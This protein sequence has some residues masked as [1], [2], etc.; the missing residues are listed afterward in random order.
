MEQYATYLESEGNDYAGWL[1]RLLVQLIFRIAAQAK[2]N[3]TEKFLLL[4]LQLVKENQGNP[5]QIYPIWAEQQERLNQ[6]LMRAIPPVMTQLFAQNATQQAYITVVLENFGNLILQFP[7]GNHWLNVEIAIAVYAQ[8]LTVRSKADMPAEWANTMN[9][10]AIAY[11]L[12]SQGD[13]AQNIEDAIATYE[14]A[15]AVYNQE[16][17]PIEWANAMMNLATVYKNR[18][19]GDKAQNIEDAITT[20]EQA[21]TVSTQAAMPVKWAQIM[22]NLANAYSDRIRGDKAQNIEDAIHARKQALTVRTQATMP[23]E[24]AQTMMNLGNTYSQRIR[25][26]KAQSIEDA[27]HAYQLALTVSTQMDMPIEWARTMMNLANTY[28]IRIRGNKAQNIEDAIHACQQA[29]TVNNQVNMPFE[30]ANTTMNLA[31]AYSERIQGDKAQN[32]E[33]AIHAY[34]QVLTVRTQATMPVQWA[35]TMTGMANA[36]LARIRGDKA[37]NIEDAIHAYQQALTVRTQATMP[38]EWEQTMTGMA[39]AYF[40]RIRGD[41][42]QNIEDAIQ[43]YQQALTVTSQSAMPFEWARTMANLANAYHDRIRG[44]KA[45]N[46]ED[47]IT[48]YQQ[49]LTVISET[50]MPIEWAKIMNN[51]AIAYYL[52]IRGDKAQNIEDAI[53][54]YQQALTVRTQAAMPMEWASTMN[55][56]A[57]AYCER[58]WGEK[59][60]NI[61]DAIVAYEASLFISDPELLPYHCRMTARSLG[62][63][64]SDQERWIEAIDRYQKALQA[65]EKIYQSAY[66]LDSKAAELTS[67]ANLPNQAA[68]AYARTGNFQAA[69]LILEQGR[70]RGLNESLN[71]DRANLTQLQQLVPHLFT[72]YQDIT[73]Q[74]RNL[75]AQQRDR[76]VSVD[77]YSLTPEIL[78][79][80]ATKLRS[81]L[82]ETIDQIRQVPGY[83]DFLASTKWEDIEITLRPDNPLLYLITTPNGSVTLIFTPDN[84]EAIWSDFTETQL[85]ELVQIWFDAHNQ[86]QDDG[87][88][89]L[90]RIDTTTRQLWDTLMGPIVQH[91][92]TLG[93]D[94]AILIPTGYLSLLPLHA[95]WTEDSTRPTGRRYAL[96]DIHFTYTPNARS[97]TAARE[98]ADLAQA[99]SILAIDN[100]RNDLPNSQREIDCA[101]D[102]FTDRTVLRQDEA[103]IS[104]VKSGLAEA[105]IVHFSCHGTVNF[106]EPLNSGLLMSDGLLTLKDFLA[107]NLAKDNGIR[108]AILSACETGL[109]GLDNIDEVVSLPVGL[110][111]A[112]VAGVIASLWSVSDLST[113]L[114]LTKFYELWREKEIPPDQAL[115]QAQIWLR[116]S[117]NDEK[118]IECKAAIDSTRMSQATAQQLYDELAWETKNERSFA[119]PFHWAAFTYTGI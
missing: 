2:V 18:M 6:E 89:W 67:T 52:R 30:W 17:M 104:A 117:T 34:Q 119:H 73:N 25:G 71:R 47:A 7:L 118:V 61:E 21:L 80:T 43:A 39:N 14:Q 16:A 26:D 13:K 28:Q 62:Q 4:T 93:I 91:L 97:L 86:K 29:L 65:A 41:K 69:S 49:A 74:L 113:M 31:I 87:P 68:Y 42:T 84:I 59:K 35:Q 76:M 79:D 33:D 3:S 46:T 55:N 78:R 32:I 90:T 110:M 60:Q 109:P 101:I 50:T 54:A 114:L 8:A 98:I 1:R 23:V 83:E 115:R 72:Q 12:R 107:L 105:S 112:G 108:L 103:T 88:T 38:M 15:L 58:V 56:L 5:Q 82:D 57:S 66:L 51:L 99:D 106:T 45:Q 24:W 100:P 111:Q 95:A 85:R 44:D 81:E 70:A 48:T 20:Y 10:L 40:A 96:D 37:Q 102:T 19:S 77:R 64:Y 22:D 36:Y 116:D 75:E 94:R 9:N 53:A 27:I 63:I 92:K 11:S